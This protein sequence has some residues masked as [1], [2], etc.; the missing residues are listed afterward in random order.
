MEIHLSIVTLVVFAIIAQPLIGLQATSFAAPQP[1]P[2]RDMIS[3]QSQPSD[4][5]TVNGVAAN[6]PLVTLRACRGEANQMWERDS[7]KSQ[8][9]SGLNVAFCLATVSSAPSPGASLT[10]RPC[11]DSRAFTLIPNP[12]LTNSYRISGTTYVLDWGVYGY[13]AVAYQN[14]W[15][16]QYWRWLQ[17]ALDV[18]AAQGCVIQYPFPASDT[19]T[20]ARE[21]ACDRVTKLQP[22]AI[23]PDAARRDPSLFPG[24][25]P[26][27][28]Q[29]ITRTFAFDLNWKDQAYLRISV[30][31]KN[32][33]STGLW[34]PAGQLVRVTVSGATTGDLQS[35]AVRIGEHTDLLK[36]DSGNVV[37]DGF[38]RYPL[39]TTRVQ[40]DPGINWVRNPYG[41][42]IVL[43][44][45]NS[46]SKVITVEVANAIPMPYLKVGET[47][48]VDWLAVR[49]SPTP[50]ASLES[51]RA[52]IHVPSSEVRGLSFA[53]AVRTANRYSEIGRLHNQLAGLSATDIITHRPPQGSYRHVEDVQISAGWGH[54]GFPMMYYNAWQLG[55][56][57][58]AID[59]STN[60]W[61]VWHEL[62]HDY[63]MDAWSYVFGTEVTVNLF[64]LH[65]QE[66]LFGNSWLVDADTYSETIGRLSDPAILDKWSGTDPFVQLVFL[67]QIR[68]GF[69]KLNW[70]LWTRLMRRYREMPVAEYEALNTDQLKR[71]KFLTTLCDITGKNLTPHF[72]A[73]TIP[74]SK[75]AKDY[76]ATKAA[77]E[78]DIWR[79]DGARPIDAGIGNGQLVRDVWT[80]LVGTSLD[81][82]T[83]SPNYPA[84]PSS[85][86]VITAGGLEGPRNGGN[87][88]GE[89]LRGYVYPPVTG[90][91]RFWLS[92]DDAVRFSLN[93]QGESDESVNITP[94]ITLSTSSGYRAFDDHVVS[95]QQSVSVTLQAGHA[96]S[97]EVLH[98]QGGG[99][100]HVSLAWTVPASATHPFEVRKVID[101]RFFSARLLV[102]PILPH[103]N[104]LPTI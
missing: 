55:V 44:A 10:V 18:V 30:P 17:P 59:R 63:Q 94:L 14:G 54:S 97:F 92:G 86:T 62:G 6:A 27:N 77:L 100:S 61:G 12:T 93:T 41:G 103:H 80:G 101:R 11:S 84:N 79:I 99:E 70:D 35:V 73:W 45:E 71:D 2:V 50:Y 5:L 65:A 37:S 82:L 48:E 104:F 29:G 33:K 13:P 4:C 66:K 22:P 95:V 46:V 83:G 20:Y 28:T 98:K 7:E 102:N 64:S 87:N 16:F 81:S 42:A 47:S 52:V 21:L 19:A 74:I 51:E 26:S 67:D 8:W 58:Y 56:P 34:A 31:P 49:N 9:R 76:C 23:V 53:E 69:P 72:G 57:D 38:N 75:P 24:A 25:V 15:D 90:E 3:P 60:G 1:T 91:Y 96:Y 39:V 85:S 36:P 89:R 40:L 43:E 88:F 68:L 32:W 78:I